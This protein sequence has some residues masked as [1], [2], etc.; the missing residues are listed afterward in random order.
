L[1]TRAEAWV[2]KASG[3]GYRVFN[4]FR[5]FADADRPWSIVIDI[6]RS[7]G[8]APWWRMSAL[9]VLVT[10]K[11]WS[12]AVVA[13]RPTPACYWSAACRLSV[14]TA[15]PSVTY[16]SYEKQTKPLS[17]KIYALVDGRN[18]QVTTV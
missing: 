15:L 9:R 16:N 18:W 13:S 17:E 3:D 6:R 8:A 1:L 12:D 7:A 2:V 5:L 4:A 14:L 11:V 10:A